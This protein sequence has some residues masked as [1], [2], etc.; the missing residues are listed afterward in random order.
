LYQFHFVNVFHDEIKFSTM[1]KQMI[2]FTV[3]GYGQM[4]ISKG[5]KE[6]AMR[7]SVVAEISKNLSKIYVGNSEKFHIFNLPNVYRKSSVL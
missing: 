5:M 4:K 2:H 6:I 3:I 1:E 7:C